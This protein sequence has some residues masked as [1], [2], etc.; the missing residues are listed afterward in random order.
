MLLL[1]N[2]N[3]SSQSISSENLFE[4]RLFYAFHQHFRTSDT[5]SGILFHYQILEG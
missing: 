2:Y 1:F 3:F 4:V 5:P